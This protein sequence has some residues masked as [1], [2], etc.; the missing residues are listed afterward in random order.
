M[1]NNCESSV[2]LAL[3]FML[4]LK[5]EKNNREQKLRL[6]S[7]KNYF[8]Q[9]I[10]SDTLSLNY[11]CKGSQKLGCMSYLSLKIY[12]ILWILA[13][14]GALIFC[15]VICKESKKSKHDGSIF[16]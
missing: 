13:V 10:L 6:Q 14:S 4:F 2:E 8:V 7:L 3:E 16:L 5:A 1:I 9:A 15:A 11:G 12:E